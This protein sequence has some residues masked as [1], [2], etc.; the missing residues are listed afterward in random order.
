MKNFKNWMAAAGVG[1]TLMSATLISLPT[2]SAQSLSSQA[3]QVATPNSGSTQ[4]VTPPSTE[5]AP[6]AQQDQATAPRIGGRDMGHRGGPIGGDQDEYLAQA[7]NITADELA[8]ARQ[9]AYES[10]V[11]QALAEGLIT[12]AQADQLKANSA[13]GDFGRRGLHIPGMDSQSI[14]M[15]ALLADAL[16]I[17]V[18]Q[19][20]AAKTEARSLAIDAAVADGSITQEQ[21]D[22]MKAESALRAYLDEQDYQGQ[23]QSLYENLVQQ[24]VTAGVITQAQAD[25]ILADD[26]GFGHGLGGPMGGR[27]GSGRA[28]MGGG[29]W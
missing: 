24:A 12:Q 8:A 10:A 28:P 13:N 15:N 16:G 11:D 3:A 21:A 14:D 2:A 26:S 19:L 5:S 29:Q 23:V 9:T 4:Q 1:L 17:T 18:D 7:L 27:G 6:A 25:A 20:A 22:E